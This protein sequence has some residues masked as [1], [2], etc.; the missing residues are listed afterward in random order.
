MW[1][2]CNKIAEK[3]NKRKEGEIKMKVEETKDVSST[4]LYNYL[5]QRPNH[6]VIGFLKLQLATYNLSGRDSTKAYNRWLRKLGQAPVIYNHQLTD[7]SVKQL[8]LAMI[9]KGYLDATVNVDTI[10]FPGKKK[11]DI[12]YCRNSHNVVKYMV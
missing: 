1:V 4:E 11:I 8:R 10:A 2:L 6:E 9:N 3:I 5:R 12:K 7:A